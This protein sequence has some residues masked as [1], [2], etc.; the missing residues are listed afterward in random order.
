MLSGPVVFTVVE[1]EVHAGSG[2]EL[3]LTNAMGVPS[4]RNTLWSMEYAMVVTKHPLGGHP[5]VPLQSPVARYQAM[6]SVFPD[7]GHT[8]TDLFQLIVPWLSQN[9]NA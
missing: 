7:P 5:Q 3:G 2:G 9:M 8:V 4:V 1:G 6:A